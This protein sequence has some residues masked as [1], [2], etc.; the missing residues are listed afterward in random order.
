MTLTIDQQCLADLI[1]ARMYRGQVK[2]S[3]GGYTDTYL[4][5]KHVLDTGDRISIALNAFGDKLF[6]FLGEEVWSNSI[7]AVGGPTMGAEVISLPFVG[8]LPGLKWFAVREPKDHG[9]GKSIE[10]ADL[11]P[12]D[13]VILTDDVVNSGGSLLKAYSKVVATGAQVVAVIPLVD[14][15]G[16]LRRALENLGVPYHPVLMYWHLGLDAIGS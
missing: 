10:G 13:K 14:R 6:E 5:I 2:L 7:T 12:E 11:G 15:T 9:M 1:K 16:A 3:T 8:H 4:D